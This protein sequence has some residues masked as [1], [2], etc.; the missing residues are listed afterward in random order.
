MN[1][2]Y[3]YA[4]WTLSPGRP[5]EARIERAISRAQ[6]CTSSRV[7]PTTVGRPVVPEE[8]CSRLT[9]RCGTANM[10]NG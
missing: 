3:P 10:P 9:S 1:S 8:A 6:V 4:T 2:P 5:P 7:Y